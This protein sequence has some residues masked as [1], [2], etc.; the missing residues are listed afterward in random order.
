MPL[1]WNPD[2]TGRYYVEISNLWRGTVLRAVIVDGLEEVTHIKE[3]ANAAG[4]AA[5]SR[6]LNNLEKTTQWLREQIE[7]TDANE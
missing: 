5:E 1:H 7:E 4:F 3:L 2:G 6:E